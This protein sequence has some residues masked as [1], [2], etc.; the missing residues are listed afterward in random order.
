MKQKDIET[1]SRSLSLNT[2]GDTETGDKSVPAV[3]SSEVPVAAVSGEY[4]RFSAAVTS[5]CENGAVFEVKSGYGTH[6]AEKMLS[7]LL[8]PQEGDQV[9]VEKIGGDFFISAVLRAG[10]SEQLRK[11][12]L[13][14]RVVMAGGESLELMAREVVTMAVSLRQNAENISRT[15]RHETVRSDRHTETSR[16]REGHYHISTETSDLLK[17]RV[18]RLADLNHKMTVLN[19]DEGYTVNTKK[20]QMR[21]DERVEINGE[22]I[23]LG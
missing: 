1:A 18:T 21:A 5:V 22:K 6:R 23:N 12:A 8:V 9:L 13:P 3:A 10:N 2:C 7:L 14:Q 4:V 16:L 15:S 11:I 19:A 17:Q 20:V